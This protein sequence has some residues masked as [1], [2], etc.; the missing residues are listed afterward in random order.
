ME[1]IKAVAAWLKSNTL[2]WELTLLIATT[3][4]TQ[5]VLG[6]GELNA[7]LAAAKSWGDVLSSFTDW[8]KAFNFSLGLTIIR[9]A[10]AFGIA[11]LAGETLG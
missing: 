2:A 6:L 5:L 4:A 7:G 3:V 8:G 11:K 10:L 9:Q 1:K